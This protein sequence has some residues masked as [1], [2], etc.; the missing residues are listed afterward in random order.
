M[1]IV[2][3]ALGIAAA[4]AF[5]IIRARHAA[6]AASELVNVAKDVR[7]AAR[8]FGFRRRSGVHPVESIDDPQVAVAALSVAFLEL[9]DLPSREAQQAL[10]RSLQ[11]A[12]GVGLGDAEELMVLG[13]WLMNECNGP[14]TATTRIGKRLYKIDGGASFEALMGVIKEIAAAGS[15]LSARQTRALD[16]LK[17][18]FRIH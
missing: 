3:A 18:A 10:G 9:D 5:W 4:A 2:V 13:R 15:G 17:R 16:D 12:F 8:R 1:H 14:D 11:H 7:L 6:D